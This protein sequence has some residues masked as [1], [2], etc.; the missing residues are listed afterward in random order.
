MYA[1]IKGE[2]AEKNIDHIVVEAGGIGYLIYVPAQSIDYLPDE[3]DQI[4]VYTYLYIREDAM[5]LYGFLTKDDL[6][7]FKMLI[8]VSGIGPKGGLGILSTLSADD[9][10]FAILSGDSKTISKAPGIG[11]KTAQRVIIDLKDKMSLEEA[12]EKKLDNNADGVQKTLNS[13]IK[14]DAVLALSALGYSSAESLKAVSKVDITDDMDVEDVLKLAL[15][16]MS[17]F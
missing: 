15:K 16:N 2:L 9:L 4:K 11:A 8:T 14:N 3:G 12:F 17:S 13:S 10:R 6:E 1:Y 7:I 5:V